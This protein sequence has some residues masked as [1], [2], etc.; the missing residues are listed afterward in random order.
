MSALGSEKYKKVITSVV[1]IFSE[2][3]C[4]RLC[5]ILENSTDPLSDLRIDS[6]LSSGAQGS[7]SVQERLGSDAVARGKKTSKSTGL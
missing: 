6:N 1:L 5:N 7:G 3:A 2:W 4:L